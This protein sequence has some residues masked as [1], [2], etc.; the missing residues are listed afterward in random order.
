MKLKVLSAA[1]EDLKSLRTHIAAD[2]PRAAN[3]VAMH[4][5]RAI[6]L[7]VSRPDIGRPTKRSG[8]REWSVSGL[9]YV[10]PY[11]VK[12]A[13]VEILRIWHTR[14]KRPDEW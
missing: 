5:G 13:E 4:L 9:P 8:I 7:I 12:D 11:R 3:D 6:Q 14:R 10:I 1:R 2:N